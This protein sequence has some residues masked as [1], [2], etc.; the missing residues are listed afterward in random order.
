MVFDNV[1]RQILKIRV[2]YLNLSPFNST[3]CFLEYE[4]QLKSDIVKHID[5]KHLVDLTLIFSQD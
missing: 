5:N 1:S 4:H 2:F 3:F